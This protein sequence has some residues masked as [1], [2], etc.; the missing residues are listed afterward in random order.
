MIRHVAG[1]GEI[2]E[3]VD[4]AAEFYRGLGLEVKVENGY[5]VVEVPGVM[6]F[7]LWA[8]RDAAQSTFGSAD[9]A[10]R[11]PLGFSLGFEVDSVDGMAEQLGT[12]ALGEAHDEPWG[13][14]VQRFRSPSG[15][16]CEITETSWA[17]ELETNVT[18][19]STEAAPA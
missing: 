13:Q 19:K 10:E 16:V 3:D 15:A 11:I 6:H 5:G 4:Q 8:R 7:G 2:V 1:F 14:R 17:R 12:I 18:A 9:D